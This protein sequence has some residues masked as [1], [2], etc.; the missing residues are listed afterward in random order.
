MSQMCHDSCGANYQSRQQ[1]TKIPL[2]GKNSY[3]CSKNSHYFSRL[4][5]HHFLTNSPRIKIKLILTQYM[6]NSAIN[7]CGRK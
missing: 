5:I 1:I 3:F 7:G 4:I 2:V 6:V